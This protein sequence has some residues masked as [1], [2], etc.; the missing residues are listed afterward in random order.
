MASTSSPVGPA[1]AVGPV[2]PGASLANPMAPGTTPVNPVAL[3]ASPTDPLAP[4][5]NPGEASAAQEH[6]A[7]DDELVCSPE[8]C[9]LSDAK[10]SRP[11][12]LT[13]RFL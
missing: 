9:F 13:T 5:A 12:L 6:I 11:H 2:A 4:G 10:S 1:T 8:Y 7:I 3:G